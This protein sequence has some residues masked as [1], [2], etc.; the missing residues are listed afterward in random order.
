MSGTSITVFGELSKPATVLVEKISDAVGGVFRPVQIVRVA[1]AE[2]QARIIH[3]EADIAITQ[4]EQRAFARLR[5]E[6]VRKQQ[7]MESITRQALPL[8]DNNAHPENV[9]DDWIAQ[10]FDKCRLI[11]DCEMQVLWSRVLAGE[12]NSPGKFSKRTIDLVSTLASNEAA[13]FAHLCT[14]VCRVDGTTRDSFPAI[15]DHRNDVYA[16]RGICF[17]SLN[18]LASIG[19][20]ILSEFAGYVEDDVPNPTRLHYF[21]NF[22]TLELP[23]GKADIAIGKAIFTQAGAELSSICS[24]ESDPRF[25]EYLQTTYEE[26][27]YR[28]VEGGDTILHNL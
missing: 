16:S 24:V 1:R 14:V 7:N 13:L 5:E 17:E 22:I 23:V 27:G 11:S 15:H 6:E 9:E 10:F 20:I 18:H 26:M 21:D 2:A 12:A 19:L 3:A 8:I 28:L 4:L 25:L